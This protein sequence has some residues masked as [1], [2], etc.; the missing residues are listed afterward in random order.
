MAKSRAIAFVDAQNLVHTAR[1]AF[2]Y[3]YPTYDVQKLAH[4]VCSPHEWTLHRV[5]FYTGITSAADDARFGIEHYSADR[6]HRLRDRASGWIA[7]RAQAKV[8]SRG[9]KFLFLAAVD[10]VTRTPLRQLCDIR[11]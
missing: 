8:A 2:G 6:H 1:S 10:G 7:R 4:A 9:L 3:S 5:Q 11:K